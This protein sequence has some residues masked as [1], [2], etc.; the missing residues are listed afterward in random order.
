MYSMSYVVFPKNCLPHFRA[1][2]TYGILLRYFVYL[3]ILN[4][5]EHRRAVIIII[6][7]AVDDRFVFVLCLVMSYVVV[8]VCTL[9]YIHLV[10]QSD[11]LDSAISLLLAALLFDFVVYC[12]NITCY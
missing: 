12:V 7:Y 5:C 6:Y 11:Q 1:H 10:I 3:Y 4:C 8:N 2:L 9:P